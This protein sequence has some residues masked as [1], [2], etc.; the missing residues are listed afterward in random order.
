[1]KIGVC[2]D[3]HDHIV[4]LKKMLT[5]FESRGVNTIIFCGDFCSPIPVREMGDFN[6]TIHCVFGNGDGDRYTMS[7]IVASSSPNVVLHGEHAAVAF[8]GVRIAFTHFPFYAEALARTGEYRAVFFGHTHVR[9]EEKIGDCLWLNPGEVMGW[10]GE[11]TCAV[12]DTVTNCAV[13]VFL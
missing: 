12:Y 5:I 4:N 9:H 3:I 11:A 7:K 1:M 13:V 10:K 8:N 2:S 6:G